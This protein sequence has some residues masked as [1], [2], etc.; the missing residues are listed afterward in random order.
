MFYNTSMDAVE[1]LKN[2]SAQMQLEP[3]GETTCPDLP[4]FKKSDFTVSHAQLPNGKQISLLKTL[5]T[6]ACERNCYYCPF[7][8]SE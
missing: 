4:E 6:S 5:L 1:Q 8:F 3:E 7:S 2:L